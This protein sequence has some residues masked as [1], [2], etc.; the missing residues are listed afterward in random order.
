M[1]SRRNY[2][3][4]IKLLLAGAALTAM[5]SVP[6]VAGGLVSGVANGATSSGTGAVGS[7]TGGAGGI[8][9]SGTTDGSG[10][11][12][13]VGASIGDTH[14]VVHALGPTGVLKANANSKLLNGI[15]A[16]VRLLTTK[17]LVKIC[18]NI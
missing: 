11:T 3:S 17:Q 1:G 18:L 8:T 15:D 9:A 10:V 7:V 14:A 16:K 2:M 13:K 6:A 12:A 5:I 4:K